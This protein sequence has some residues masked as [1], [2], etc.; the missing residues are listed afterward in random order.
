LR[1]WSFWVVALAAGA[2]IGV[3]IALVHRSSQA[4]RLPSTVAGAPAVTWA[5]GARRAPD[6]SLSDQSGKPVSIAAFRGRPVIVT[7]IDPLCRNFCPLEAKVLNAV[8]AHLPVSERPPIV[9]VS[10]DQW[11]DARRFLVQDVVEWKL[12]P[13]WHWAVGQPPA[14][15]KVWGAYQIG[16]I[17]SP[18][19]VAG[20]TVHNISHTEAAFLVDPRGYQRAL[21]M[22]PFQAADVER[23]VRR[24]AGA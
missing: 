9:A 17:D 8:E 5:A 6:F 18:K 14:L 10:V 15:R 13:S 3:L 24:L 23:V 11:G 19:T 22:W 4:P 7:F 1:G 16:V 20:V 12:S 2:A 21:L